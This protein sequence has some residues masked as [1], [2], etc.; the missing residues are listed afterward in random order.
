V[1]DAALTLGGEAGIGAGEAAQAPA[2]KS[3]DE[4]WAEEPV[5]FG[6]AAAPRS[7]Q[8]KRS[9]PPHTKM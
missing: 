6:P 4:E 1:I 7:S 8:P 2:E 5:V 9:T 3:M